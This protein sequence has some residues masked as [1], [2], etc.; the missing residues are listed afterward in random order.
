MYINFIRKYVIMSILNKP[1]L[2]VLST[3]SFAVFY[4][5][6]V[7]NSTAQQPAA[8]Q[9]LKPIEVIG[10]VEK[11][12][13]TANKSITVEDIQKE[14]PIDLHHLFADD[15]ALQVSSGTG[16]AQQINIRNLGE[17][18]LILKIDNTSKS[19]TMFH[20][21]S[22]FLFDPQLIKQ[23]EIQ[24]GAGSASAGFGVTGGQIR[25]TTISAKDVLRDNETAGAKVGGSVFNNK[26][27]EAH[28]QLFTKAGEN[29]DVLFAYSYIDQ[30]DYKTGN[31]KVAPYSALKQNN[32][33]LK[34]GL[35]LDAKQRLQISHRTENFSGNKPLRLNISGL[36]NLPA[37]DTDLNQHTT[38]LEY[39]AK[40]IGDGNQITAN[41]FSQEV[42]ETKQALG[43][44][45]GPLPARSTNQLHSHGTNFGINYAMGKHIL[46]YG[47]N[48]QNE[49]SLNTTPKVASGKEH[50][51]QMGL[52]SEIIWDFAPYTLT[53]GVRYDKY[54]LTNNLK[55]TNSNGGFNPSVGII[56]DFQNGI[57]LRAN[58]TNASRAPHLQEAYL[59]GLP[60]SNYRH[61]APN[62]K[63]EKA[64][65]IEIGLEYKNENWRWY[66]SVYELKIKNRFYEE[67]QGDIS[68]LKNSGTLTNKGYELGVQYAS[69][70]FKS[71]AQ[72]AYSKPLID[73]KLPKPPLWNDVNPTGKT[74]VVNAAYLPNKQ[75]TTGWRMRSTASV[76][77]QDAQSNNTVTRQGYT[78]HDTYISWE[79]TTKNWLLSLWVNNIS[80]RQY[81]DQSNSLCGPTNISACNADPGRNVKL[82]A[83][84]R[85]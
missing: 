71:S 20:H 36:R 7:Q 63:A 78:I 82:I 44:I 66:G 41:I 29:A 9:N 39:E 47:L 2:N 32:I 6:N 59:L 67:E 68:I 69:T 38:N 58:Y 34:G 46:S 85:F 33:L 84:F 72:M 3:I 42:E 17:D 40:N 57:N 25:V 73:G 54:E 1:P 53:T 62:L 51:N 48:Y 5:C 27:K 60:W 70:H 35:D 43:P 76:K 21:Q 22:S 61:I 14:R 83:N 28:T 26:G 65:N 75:L 52:Y 30:S 18:N 49:T 23:I 4:L 16:L 45:K 19:G 56:R 13:N 50:L 74:L 64:N 11:E 10:S 15:A 79:G 81:L 31:G 37:F 77:T 12:G 55:Q 24:K 8:P 80:N